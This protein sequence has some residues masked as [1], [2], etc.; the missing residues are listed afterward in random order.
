MKLLWSP[1]APFVRKVMVAAQV[2]DLAESIECVRSPVG[3]ARLNP[4]VMASNPLNKVPT[5][6][7][8][9]GTALYDS[10]VICDYLDVRAGG[11]VLVPRDPDGR[12]QALRRQCLADGMLDMLIL[13]R[14]E[15]FRGEGHRSSAHV[16]AYAT[17][18]QAALDA[19][20]A[21]A[22]ALAGDTIDIGRIAIGVALAYLDFRVPEERWRDGRPRLADWEAGFAR[23]PAMQAVPFVDDGKKRFAFYQIA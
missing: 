11:G 21:E 8:E 17:K 13:R 9:D 7:L 10:R 20:E 16:H 19:M 3:P 14:D 18:T 4:E 5:L 22:E 23:H 6:L 15:H 1:S 2:A 12:W